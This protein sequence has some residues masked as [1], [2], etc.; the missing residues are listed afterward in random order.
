[1]LCILDVLLIFLQKISN[2]FGN[3]REVQDESTIIVTQ[4]KETVNMVHSPGR[5]PI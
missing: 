4:P 1:M 5:L 2:E 3:L